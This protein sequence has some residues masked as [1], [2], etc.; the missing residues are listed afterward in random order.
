MLLIS[1]VNVTL[2][3][4]VTMLEADFRPTVSLVVKVARRSNEEVSVP[5]STM[6]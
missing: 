6:G 3:S 4:R 2:A 1:L 5:S